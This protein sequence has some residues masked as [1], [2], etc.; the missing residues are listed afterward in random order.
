MFTACLLSLQLL[1]YRLTCTYTLGKTQ[2]PRRYSQGALGGTPRRIQ[3]QYL[4]YPIY[5]PFI[6]PIYLG[7][8]YN[9][10]HKL[11]GSLLRVLL[12]PLDTAKVSTLTMTMMIVVGEGPEAVIELEMRRPSQSIQNL[13]PPAVASGLLT[14]PRPIADLARNRKP[15][16]P[17]RV[18]ST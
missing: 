15:L 5:N 1:V 17:L 7:S 18:Q 10:P 9:T 11:Q 12:K 4:I 6:P 3:S 14:S 8:P 13:P 2:T 16:K